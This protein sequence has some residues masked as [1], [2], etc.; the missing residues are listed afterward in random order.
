MALARVEVS[1]AVQGVGF[2]WFTREAAR[3][4]DLAGWVRNRADGH[5]E[6]AVEGDDSLVEQFLRQVARGPT[7]AV[8]E[9]VLHL[10]TTGLEALPRPFAILH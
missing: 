4:L 8:V 2:R 10:P 3:R 7:G 5:V 6:I 1:G 9:Q